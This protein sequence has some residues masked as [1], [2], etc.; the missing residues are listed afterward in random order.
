MKKVTSLVL[1]LVMI[2]S[3]VVG[4]SQGQETATETTRD[5]SS[6]EAVSSGIKDTCHWFSC[7]NQQ[8]GPVGP[9]RPDQQYLSE[10]NP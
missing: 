7:R 6:K 9:K 1:C 4:C 5:P 10:T 2:F 8:L 3:L